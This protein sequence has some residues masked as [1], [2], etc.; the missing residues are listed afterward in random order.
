M[1][2]VARTVHKAVRVELL[3]AAHQSLAHGLVSENRELLDGGQARGSK[4][5]E[6]PDVALGEF[7]TRA[8]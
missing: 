6:D 7:K 4:D 1:R 8:V 3:E 5:L 2:L